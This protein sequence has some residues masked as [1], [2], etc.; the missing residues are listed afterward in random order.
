MKPYRFLL[1]FPLAFLSLDCRQ[2][3]EAPAAPERLRDVAGYPIGAAVSPTLLQTRPAY[4]TLAE[5]EYTSLTAENAMKMRALHPEAARYDWSGADVI[6]NLAQQNKT[7]VHGHTLLWHLSIPDWVTNV[8]GDAAA[9]EALLK[10]H[11]QTVVGHY[12]GK[13]ASWDV[14]NEA[15]ND[16]GTLR[17]TLWLQKLG[18]DYLARCFQYARAADPNVK[19]FYNDYGQEYAP[20]KMAAILA[21]VADFKRRGVPI[22]G[23]G[24][25]MHLGLNSNESGIQTVIRQATETGLLVHLSELDISVN[26]KAEANFSYSDDVKAKQTAKYELVFRAYRQ[27]PA[28]QRFGITTWNIGDPDSW[29]RSYYKRED[30]P[31]LF[32]DQYQRKPV[33][34]RLLAVLREK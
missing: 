15:F 20:K 21:M 30:Y 5:T 26:P 27:V 9:W 14:V 25:Q 22:D 16:D 34:G 4:R 6:V 32:D 31:L 18:P 13:V 17:N 24:L 19:L 11:I 10:E 8:Q 29:I 23:L 33:Y 1:L 7:R 2:A 28:A 12:R 3:A